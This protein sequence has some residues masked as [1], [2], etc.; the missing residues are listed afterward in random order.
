MKWYHVCDL[1]WLKERQKH[2]CASDIKKLLPFT[3]TGR[4]K[5]ITDLDRAQVYASKLKMLTADDCVSVGAAAR[6]HMLEPY[7]VAA[8]NK[9]AED[10]SYPIRF[11]HWDDCVIA[12]PGRLLAYSPDA[13]NFKQPDDAI[14]LCLTSLHSADYILEIKSY[15]VDAHVAAI[16]S[17]KSELEERWQLATAMAADHNIKGAWIAFF[18]PS[19]KEAKL[20]VF[21]YDRMDLYDEINTVEQIEAEYEDFIKRDPFNLPNIGYMLGSSFDEENIVA[22][23][24]ETERLNP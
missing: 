13:M 5:K 24:E 9:F 4:P 12:E 8:F 21:D 18:N 16:L 6:G 14:P 17:D 1:E 11:E 2:L 20:G 10:N 23:I 22:E 3:K 19:L 15:N 7:A